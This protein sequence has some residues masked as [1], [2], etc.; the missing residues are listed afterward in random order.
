MTS[1]PDGFSIRPILCV[2]AIWLLFLGAIFADQDGIVTTIIFFFISTIIIIIL[3]SLFS[4]FLFVS[5]LRSL[6]FAVA[7]MLFGILF[8]LRNQAF[9]FTDITKLYIFHNYYGRCA[10]SASNYGVG[11]L[12]V[13]DHHDL[14]SNVEAIIFDSGD[15]IAKPAAHRSSEWEKAAN[16]LVPAVPF[17]IEGFTATKI[18]GHFY[19]VYFSP[20]ESPGL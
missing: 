6:S 9:W 16:A 4:Y 7:L 2:A 10:S 13:C 14:D 12:A 3:L 15:E 8:V 20:E 5:R 17:G 18:Y 1:R 19:R 11:V